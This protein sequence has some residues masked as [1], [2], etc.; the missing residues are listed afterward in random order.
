[1][2]EPSEKRVVL[3]PHRDYIH[4]DCEKGLRELERRGVAVWRWPGVSAIDSAHCEYA[5]GALHDGFDSIL[6]VDSDIQ[7]LADDAIKL[8]DSP[9][10]VISGVYPIKRNRRFVVDWKPGTKSVKFGK[11]AP[12]P[13]EVEATG[14]GFLRIKSAVLRRMIDELKLP[15][16]NTPFGRGMWPFFLPMLVERPGYTHYMGEDWAFCHRLKQ[17][18]EP[19]FADTSI[20]LWH[21]GDYPYGWED[22]GREIERFDLDYTW[23]LPA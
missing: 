8:F 5:S 17:I 18:G 21:I 11:D 2:A 19:L 4:H 1:M 16:C 7:F 20:R 12:P 13:F 14:G 22:A 9:H 23:N 10:G 6:F 3:V 15:S